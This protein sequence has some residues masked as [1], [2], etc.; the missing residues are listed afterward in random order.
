MKFTKIMILAQSPKTINI[1][2]G[3][4]SCKKGITKQSP[5]NKCF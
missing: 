5:D 4:T 2:I 3:K 1:N